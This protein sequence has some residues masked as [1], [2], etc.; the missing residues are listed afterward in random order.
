VPAGALATPVPLAIRG[1]SAVPLDPYAVFGGSI[2]VGPAGTT[3]ATPATLVLQYSSGQPPLGVDEGELRLHVLEGGEW[4]PLPG[5]SVDPT[6][7]EVSAP[8]GRAGVFA[9]RWVVGPSAACSGSEAGQFDFWLGNWDLVAAGVFHGTNDVVRNG[10][11]IEEDFRSAGGA[12][13]RSVSFYSGVS[14]QWYQTYIDSQ[15]HRLPLRGMSEGGG[16][17]LYH[18]LG[19]AR[20]TWQPQ[21]RERVRFFQESLTGGSWRVGFDSVYVRR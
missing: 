8:I 12:V 17:V 5:G 13:G 4:R 11:V 2:E 20:S 14:R 15:G 16:I 19:G 18:E 1:T 21:S 9:A 10:C 6:T 7:R 3:F